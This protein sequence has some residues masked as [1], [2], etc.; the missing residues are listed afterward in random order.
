MFKL[1]RKI[2]FKFV[3]QPPLFS[4][5][6]YLCI[7]CILVF[8]VPYLTRKFFEF[9]DFLLVSIFIQNFIDFCSTS[10][11]FSV[12]IITNPINKMKPVKELFLWAAPITAKWVIVWCLF[13]LLFWCFETKTEKLCFICYHK[14]R[15]WQG[16]KTRRFAKCVSKYVITSLRILLANQNLN[17]ASFITQS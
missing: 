2:Y 16:K 15:T 10:L 1:D 11:R 3:F 17:L 8:W 4:L 5:S 6:L 7:S 14:D 9:F 13:N 12:S